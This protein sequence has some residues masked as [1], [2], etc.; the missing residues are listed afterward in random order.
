MLNIGQVVYDETNKRVVVFA[1]LEMLR[2]QETGGCRSKSGFILKDGTF[3]YLD[4]SP[5]KYTNLTK[6]GK[7]FVG[8]FVS[9]AKCS[10]Y[11]FGVIDGN[12]AEVKVW[13]KEAIEEM[14]AL[15]AEHGLNT[16][17]C[18]SYKGPYT[19]YHI[20]PIKKYEHKMAIDTPS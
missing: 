10:G 3:I 6:D 7:A 13:A 19:R 11:Y 8:S 5:F 1:G 9:K 20:G 14:E 18:E 12:D 4:K 16:E 15:I 17:E 2:N